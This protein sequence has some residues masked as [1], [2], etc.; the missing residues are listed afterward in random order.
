MLAKE[1]SV[2]NGRLCSRSGPL[3]PEILSE[4]FKY[5]LPSESTRTNTFLHLLPPLTLTWVCRY[6]R[7]LCLSLPSLW[8]D[9]ILGHHG[10]DPEG[11]TRILDMWI[12]RSGCL[13]MSFKLNHESKDELEDLYFDPDETYTNGIRTL[14]GKALPCVHR[15]R[16]FEIH[17]LD[18]SMLE[19][20]FAAQV[21]DAPQLE[22]L[23]FSAT[24]LGFFG[25]VRRL[26][27]SLC[28]SL[29]TICL[30]IPMICPTNTAIMENMTN[31]E[32][33]FCTSI[34]DCLQWIDICPAL[35]RLFVRLFCS[36]PEL[37]EQVTEWASSEP[38]QGTMRHL[39]QLTHLE[40]YGTSS[41]TDLGPL[42]DVLNVPALRSLQ[43]TMLDMLDVDPDW[44][45]IL[46]CVRRSHPPLET[47]KISGT[48]MLTEDI[49]ECLEL[50][51]GLTKLS[52]GK[53]HQ[54][55]ILIQALSVPQHNLRAGENSML[56]GA[57]HER[58]LCPSL[59]ALDIANSVWT[60]ELLMDMVA[61][62]C[63]RNHVT[64]SSGGHAYLEKLYIYE[65]PAA[66]LMRH[67]TI[68][69]CLD[70]G[71]SIVERQPDRLQDIFSPPRIVPT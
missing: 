6:W 7:N 40:I 44:T 58:V 60:L 45:H 54:A 9:V 10:T 35:E 31:L 30:R 24:Y 71:L 51:P 32:L 61:S 15:W 3:P 23:G 48:P 19:Q 53:A 70:Q 37:L 5:C 21:I 11:D 64:E 22:C 25:D 33:W 50:L 13:P 65:T 49:L 34:E 8:T 14:I 12:P 42:I 2:E 66:A 68:R 20:V 16:K 18:V 36:R 62:R 41:E 43:V 29:K 1:S 28:S 52:L 56:P 4:I 55:D 47:L 38:R 67:H 57:M 39:Q 69:E 63:L 27:F 26:D 46:D 59:K 17:A